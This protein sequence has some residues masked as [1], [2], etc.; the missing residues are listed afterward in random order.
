MKK[1]NLKIILLKRNFIFQAETS[2]I[3]GI[4]KGTPPNPP[5][6][7]KKWPALERWLWRENGGSHNVRFHVDLSKAQ[8]TILEKQIQVGDDWGEHMHRT[9]LRLKKKRVTC[10]GV[11]LFKVNF[12]M[13]SKSVILFVCLFVSFFVCLFCWMWFFNMFYGFGSHGMKITTFHNYLGD[14]I[15][16]GSTHQT[17]ANPGCYKGRGN[18]AACPWGQTPRSTRRCSKFL[19]RSFLISFKDNNFVSWKYLEIVVISCTEWHLFLW[20]GRW[21]DLLGITWINSS[22]RETGLPIKRAMHWESWIRLDHIA[23]QSIWKILVEEDDSVATS[24]EI[25]V[26]ERLP[27]AS[28]PCRPI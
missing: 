4:F 1:R 11:C 6:P 20:R 22:W 28:H 2:V 19:T 14:F 5:N 21:I 3:I 25:L 27:N 24:E 12:T 10:F 16:A 17:V 23:P 26:G 9:K 8:L 13:V 18:F 15:Q 7:P